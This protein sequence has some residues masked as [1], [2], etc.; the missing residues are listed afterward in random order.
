MW[1]QGSWWKHVCL[2]ASINT[3]IWL[4]SASKVSSILKDLAQGSQVGFCDSSRSSFSS[5][6]YNLLFGLH[7]YWFSSVFED[8]W[9]EFEVSRL[10]HNSKSKTLI[11]DRNWRIFFI[12]IVK[13]FFFLQCCE[14]CSPFA[15]F[16]FR[17][18]LNWFLVQSLKSAHLCGAGLPTR[19]P[20][21]LA[22]F[23]PISKISL[24]KKC[25]V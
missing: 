19:M 8:F 13:L 4:Y 18:L 15:R 25:W 9:L 6:N 21:L 1:Q 3:M 2:N 12:D 22:Y 14:V 17:V 23:L 24:F 11:W 16:L 5:L 20:Y 7:V 10:N